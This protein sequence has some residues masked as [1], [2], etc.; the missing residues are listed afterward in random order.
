MTNEEIL[1]RFQAGIDCGQVVMENYAEKV[2]V[3]I[4]SARKLASTFGGGFGLGECCG[5]VNA[6]MILIGMKYGYSED[7]D[8]EQKKILNEKKDE[9]LKAFSEKYSDISCKGLL[10]HN[11]SEPGEYEKIVEEGLMISLCPQ[12]V[13]DV[14]A[15]LKDTI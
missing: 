1:L 15:I 12:I 5:A 6:A 14:M 2:D 9:F 10:G 13:N 7:N 4:E 3:S 11:I 8:L